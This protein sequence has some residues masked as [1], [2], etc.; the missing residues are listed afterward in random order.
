MKNFARL[1][2]VAI[3]LATPIAARAQSDIVN[4]IFNLGGALIINDALRRQQQQQQTTVRPRPQNTAAPRANDEA[5]IL[6]ME[7]Q[8]RLNLLGFDA[9]SPDGVFGPRSRR[10][11]AAYQNSIGVTPTG[12]ITEGEIAQLYQLTDQPGGYQA[13]PTFAPNVAA[14]AF[15][16]VGAPG[17]NPALPQFP[18]VG[19]QQAAMA[20]ALGG[21]P[22]LGGS[23]TP[24]APA[25]AAFPPVGGAGAPAPVATAAFPQ[26]GGTAPTAAPGTGAFPQLGTPSPTQQQASAFPALGSTA[27]EAQLPTAS[28][29]QVGAAPVQETAAFPALGEEQAAPVETFTMPLNVDPAVQVAEL[30][31]DK[32]PA[33]FGLATAMKALPYQTIDKQP[34]IFGIGLGEKAEAAAA[35]LTE[36]GFPECALADDASQLA[37]TRETSNL[38]ET[39]TIAYTPDTTIWHLSRSINFSTQMD[40]SLLQ[41]QMRGPYPELLEHGRLVADTCTEA[42]YDSTLGGSLLELSATSDISAIAAR[43]DLVETVIACPLAYEMRLD[44]QDKSSVLAIGFTH[45]GAQL[46]RL[47]SDD[48]ERR[49]AEA[50]LMKEVVGGLEF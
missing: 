42:I 12:N 39:V 18:A 33:S 6:R 10:A 13:A 44:G 30:L 24:A 23:T 14:G 1:S 46:A 27:P 34:K 5:R 25:I 36:A 29:P 32:T 35:A 17:G 26:V 2:I 15:P 4:G 20:P 22:A 16:P 47:M 37:C 8:R 19:G 43:P 41:D 50:D 31:A 45:G 40:N 7:I 48:I 11:I 49:Q 28:F 38:A 9:G 21:F 3:A